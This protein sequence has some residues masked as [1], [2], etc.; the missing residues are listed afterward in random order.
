MN[1]HILKWNILTK[2]F[3]DNNTHFTHGNT[4][5]NS[6]VD[7]ATSMFM[8]ILLLKTMNAQ[9]IAYVDNCSYQ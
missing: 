8:I 1:Q 4:E 6:I 7:N 5:H 3:H 2:L 9:N